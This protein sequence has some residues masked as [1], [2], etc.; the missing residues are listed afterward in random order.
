LR[1]F[2]YILATRKAGPIYVGVTSHLQKRV[3]EHKARTVA[4]YTKRYNIDRLVWF[5][6]HATAESA[7]TK[8]KRLKRWQ[9]KWKNELIEKTNPEWNDLYEMLDPE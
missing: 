5:E 2:V 9:R 4:G 8:E 7:I 3:Y 6:P 1:F